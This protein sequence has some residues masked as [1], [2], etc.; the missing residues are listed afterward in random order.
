MTAAARRVVIVDDHPLLAAGLQRELER[1]GAAV[2]VVDP[3]TVGDR[4]VETI[5]AR[6]PD[7]AVVDLGLPLAGGGVALIAP[8]VAD[9]YRVVVL[10][11]ETDRDAWARSSGQGAEVVLSKADPLDAIVDTILRVADGDEIGLRQRAELEAE[12]RQLAI[13]EAQRMALFAHLSPREEQV[14]AGL[15]DGLA[16]ADIA[17]RD[18]VSIAT[19]RTQIKSL[20]RKL[21]VGSQLEAVALAHRNHWRPGGDAR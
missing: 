21:G 1:S 17:E 6:H 15:M 2:D 10:T 16:P 8:L 3:V 9:G 19:V 12:A 5:V 14:L 7:C 11:G 4:V 20:L 13:E 18:Y